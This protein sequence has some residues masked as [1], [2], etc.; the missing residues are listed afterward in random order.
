MLRIFLLLTLLALAV[1]RT[2]PVYKQC[3]SSWAKEQLGTSNE[4]ICSQGSLITSVA[5]ALKGVDKNF[6]PSTL[7]TWL[8][9]N[10]GYI[11]GS[12]FVWN[13]INSLGLVFQGHVG[14]AQIRASFDAGKVVIVE[15]KATGD[16]GVMTGYK[17][18]TININESKKGATHYEIF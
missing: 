11:G 8:K 17:D 14:I 2:Y 15:V 1:S 18:Q 5:M 10:K 7:N 16:W 6:N 9:N 12:L 3:D 4:T 13:S